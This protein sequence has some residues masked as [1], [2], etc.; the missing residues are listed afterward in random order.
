MASDLSGRSSRI[1]FA[2]AWIAFGALLVDTG[3]E[4]W[5]ESGWIFRIVLLASPFAIVA[6]VLE[7]LVK[8]IK[9]SGNEIIY[10]NSFG[11]TRVLPIRNIKQVVWHPAGNLEVH[12]HDGMKLPV[13]TNDANTKDFYN[14]L[15]K[16]IAATK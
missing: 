4:L 6:G 16:K 10:R 7:A 13:Y 14:E 5:D 8:S 12:F 15:T 3:S 11:K 2:G 9:L 1:I